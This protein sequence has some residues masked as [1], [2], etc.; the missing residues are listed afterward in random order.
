MKL[1]GM[2]PPIMDMDGGTLCTLKNC[3]HLS[4]STNLIS[5]MQPI[6]GMIKL[7]VLSLGRNNLSKI[8]NLEGVA[9]TLDQLWLSYNDIASLSGLERCRQLRVLCIANNKI[10]KWEEVEKL[11]ELPLIAE[12]VLKGNP[13]MLECKDGT[14]G[15]AKL[16][17]NLLPHLQ[18]LDGIATARWRHKIDEHHSAKLKNLFD[19]MDL[20][21]SGSI[22]A[23]EMAKVLKNDDE[24]RR[25]L[26]VVK[27]K[28]AE[29]FLEMDEDA[30]GDISWD[31]FLL[32]FS[33]RLNDF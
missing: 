2:N 4:L 31:E 20:D 21:R 14:I 3:E 30:G 32:F 27:G 24:M 17:L 7:K 26:G 6:G 11:K 15:Y 12:V 28:E 18:K 22:S 23:P 1:Y 19:R 25:S 5:K 9:P 16:V 13:I 10:K 29:L 33:Q 8:E